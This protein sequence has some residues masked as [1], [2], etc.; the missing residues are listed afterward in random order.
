MRRGVERPRNDPAVHERSSP[1]AFV[2]REPL[3]FGPLSSFSVVWSSVF[4]VKGDS[5]GWPLDAATGQRKHDLLEGGPWNSDATMIRMQFFRLD[6]ALL[7][8]THVLCAQPSA[9]PTVKSAGGSSLASVVAGS[10]PTKPLNKPDFDDIS[11]RNVTAIVEQTAELNCFV[12]HPG[13][14][15][16]NLNPTKRACFLGEVACIPIRVTLIG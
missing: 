11:P 2:A 13:D 12:K 16:I 10:K 4:H 6:L 14:R 15:V 7:G 8:G 9:S 3:D 1:F 5:L